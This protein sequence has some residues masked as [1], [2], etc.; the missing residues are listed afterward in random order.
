MA[1]NK[2]IDIQYILSEDNHVDI[3]TKNT[4][5]ADFA[6]HMKR[7]TEGELWDFVGI[8][9]ENVKNT[10]VTNDVITYYKTKY[11]SYA[12]AEAVNGKHKIEWILVTRSRI[13][14]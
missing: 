13:G 9:R 5:E 6:R 12:L 1:E 11:S 2:D 4:S 10:R 8:V 7:I 14:K 3:M